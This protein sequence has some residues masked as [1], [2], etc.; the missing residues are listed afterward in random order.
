MKEGVAA[1]VHLIAAT[2]RLRANQQVLARK[3]D[4]ESVLLNP[5]DGQYY[6]LDD[7]GGRVWELCDGTHTLL[8][9]AQIISRE[10]EADPAVVSAD[11]E[12][13]LGDLAEA[14]L[15]ETAI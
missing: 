11:L 6:A 10:F 9:I 8:E 7:V 13:L 14:G 5:A 12:E 15:V 3:V 4:E 2:G 1:R